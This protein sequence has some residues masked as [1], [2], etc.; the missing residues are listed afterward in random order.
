[1]GMIRDELK[2]VGVEIKDKE[3]MWCSSD[4]HGGRIANWCE[5]GIV[6]PQLSIPQ[7]PQHPQLAI[8][9]GVVSADLRSQVVQAAL[10]C[11][12]T[13]ASAMRA[14][15][16]LQQQAGTIAL[17]HTPT[18]NV[19]RPTAVVPTIAVAANPDFTEALNFVTRF[20]NGQVMSDSEIAWLIEV[21]EKLRLRKDFG[22]ADQLRAAMREC[23]L[24]I[25]FFET[26]K[27]WQANDGRSGPIPLFANIV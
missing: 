6:S 5:V 18:L 14:L 26:E 4:G 9:V 13:P 23:P 22:M 2:S 16:L 12:Q 21:R 17:P 8:P 11:C 3:K 15:Q 27:R 25:E 10:N 19:A 20:Q 7:Q 1:M 24:S